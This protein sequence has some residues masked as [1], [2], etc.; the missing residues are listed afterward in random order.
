VNLEEGASARLQGV[1]R[2]AATLTGGAVAT[3]AL[4]AVRELFLAVN[5]GA[6]GALDAVLIALILP[7]ALAGVLTSGI[8]R[9]IVPAYLEAEHTGGRDRA[10]RLAGSLVVWAGVA[11]LVLWLLLSLLSGPIVSVAGPGLGVDGRA[12]AAGYLRLLAPIALVTTLSTILAAVCQ[13]EERFAAIALSG[14]AGTATVLATMLALW[15]AVGLTGLVIGTLLGAL[16]TLVI[17]VVAAIRGSFLPIP[18]IRRDA[19]VDRLLRHAA[20]LT[21]SAAI[22]QINVI[23]DRAIASLLGPGAVSILRY[24]DVLVR[25]PF[26]AIGPAWGAA[27]YPALVRSS[28]AG[29]PGSLAA[30]TVRAVHYILAIFVPVA[31]LTAAVAPL[32]VA[33]AYGRGA[34]AAEDVSR[35]ARTVAGFAPLL[36]I[37]MLVPIL[38]GAHNARRRGTLLLVGGITNVAINMTLDLGLSAW[39]GVPGIAVASSVAEV[40]VLLLF[41]HRLS[42][43]GDRFELREI[44]RKTALALLASAPGSLLVAVVVWSGQV[45]PGAVPAIAG[46]IAAGLFGAGTYLLMARLMRLDEPLAVWRALTGRFR[47]RS[48]A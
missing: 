1:A 4:G 44:G 33:A 27:I 5:V 41:I 46:L 24:A 3:Q 12:D 18:G 30:T 9:A 47:P 45:P 25:V 7:S 40:S 35:T 2:S 6:T 48:E 36:V 10:R 26:G 16:V 38:T 14:L 42:R 17:L 32:A 43:D 13:A 29:I 37:L 23:G 19:E 11:G 39:I 8:V 22:L 15:G 21:V 20:P 34:F 28:L 31:C